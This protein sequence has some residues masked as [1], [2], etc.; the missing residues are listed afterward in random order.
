MKCSVTA[1]GGH[2]VRITQPK[3]SLPRTLRLTMMVVVLGV[4]TW[5]SYS[6]LSP[7]A[8]SRMRTAHLTVTAGL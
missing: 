6:P 3:A 5:H 4:V 7:T 1:E 8:A 2:D